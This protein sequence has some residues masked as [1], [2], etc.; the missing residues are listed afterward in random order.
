M[1]GGVRGH[2]GFRGITPDFEVRRSTS[3]KQTFCLATQVYSIGYNV[4]DEIRDSDQGAEV[5]RCEI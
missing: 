4:G 1:W 5:A 3:S 2:R